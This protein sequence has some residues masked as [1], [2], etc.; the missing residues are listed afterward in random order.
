LLCTLVILNTG[1]SSA[2][3]YGQAHMRVADRMHTAE[4]VTACA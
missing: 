4:C 3:S 1:H 2:A